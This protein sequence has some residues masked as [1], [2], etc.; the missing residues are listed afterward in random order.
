MA[1]IA[2]SVEPDLGAEEF[3]DVLRRS[4]LAARRP[5]D[6]PSTIAGMLA[7]ADNS[8]RFLTGLRTASSLVLKIP[9]KSILIRPGRGDILETEGAPIR[10]VSN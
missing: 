4:T 6:R 8:I 2:Y 7:H 10:K 9:H 1:N 3:V 5:V